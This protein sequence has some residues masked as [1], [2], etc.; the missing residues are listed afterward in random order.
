MCAKRVLWHPVEWEQDNELTFSCQLVCGKERSKMS[1]QK[2]LF[3]PY[4]PTTISSATKGTRPK[5]YDFIQLRRIH[6]RFQHSVHDRFKRMALRMVLKLCWRAKDLF[7]GKLRRNIV[8]YFNKDHSIVFVSAY[9]NT[10]LLVTY[11]GPISEYRKIHLAF[12]RATV[13]EFAYTLGYRGFLQ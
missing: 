11:E 12:T 1:G 9:S 3:R 8:N 4:L 10:T 5:E 13:I 7:N 2:E 6:Y